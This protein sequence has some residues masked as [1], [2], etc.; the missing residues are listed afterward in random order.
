MKRWRASSALPLRRS[1]STQRRR[2][3]FR[4]GGP[5]SSDAWHGCSCSKK[6]S[7]LVPPDSG[8]MSAAPCYLCD[9]RM[10]KQPEDSMRRS[11]GLVLVLAIALTDCT[12]SA[13]SY[14][15]P[16]LAP[17]PGSITYQGQPRTKLTRS[18]V[19]SS[20]TDQWG[21]Q[22]EEIYI[23]RPDRSLLIAERHYRPV[24]LLDDD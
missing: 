16:G 20:F 6:N 2:M 9:R 18:P 21:R 3:V 7:F 14:S 24:F 15:S 10:P 1:A 22:V 5:W 4:R 17:V 11:M 13:G 8:T 12:T 19:G 23:I